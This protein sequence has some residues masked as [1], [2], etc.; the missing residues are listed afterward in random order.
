MIVKTPTLGS[1]LEKDSWD[2][3]MRT[4]FRTHQI[5]ND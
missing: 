2:E 4:E 3:E 5:R 1:F